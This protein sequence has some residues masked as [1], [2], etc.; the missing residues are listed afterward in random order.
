MTFDERRVTIALREYAR[1]I[2]VT[3][4]DLDR[5]EAGLDERLHPASRRDR[6][7]RPWDWAVA[8]CAV[9]ALVLGVTALWRTGVEETMPAAP[10]TT[11]ADLAGTWLVDVE[12]DDWLWHFAADG[13]LAFSSTASAYIKRYDETSFTLEGDVLSHPDR[14]EVCRSTVRLSAQGRMTLTPVLGPARCSLWDRG[15]GVPWPFI[16]VSPASIPGTTLAVRNL[17]RQRPPTQAESV[18]DVVGTWLLEGTGTILVVA[19]T[20]PGVGQYVIDDDGD[21]FISPDQRG[22]L[23]LRPD[24]GVVLSPERGPQEGC[25]TV[26]SRVV[27]TGATLEVELDAT[28]CG[29]LGAARHTWIRLN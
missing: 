12:G 10:S 23:I 8:A 11:P 6:G 13:R 25:E 14:G 1:G 19:R 21:G 26:Y 15:D 3:D 2:D 28:S 16:R 7:R 18:G 9:V 29:R 24:G 20:S 27:T 17:D 22:R 4:P 5:L